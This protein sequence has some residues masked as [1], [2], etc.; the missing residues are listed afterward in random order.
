MFI[1]VIA[2]GL[3][4]GLTY[5]LVASGFNLAI[6]VCRILNFAHGEFYML[7]AFGVYYLFELLGLNYSLAII[8]SMAIVASLGIVIERLL[9][10]R[11]RGQ[12]LPTMITACAVMF[13]IA[14]AALVIFGEKSSGVS[15]IFSGTT[16]V[17]GASIATERWVIIGA[18]IMIIV[19]LHLFIRNTKTGRS[20][21][22][23]A[24]DTVGAALQG[25][26]IDNVSSL[27]MGLS[28]ALAAVAGGLMA[29]VFVVSPFLGSHALLNAFVVAVLG[30]MGSMPGAV[31]GGLL[32]GLLESFGFT[33][34]G[35]FAEVLVLFLVM[36]VILIKPGGLLGRPMVTEQ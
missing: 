35:C 25:I 22:A 15:S 13:F 21:R 11:L 4:I 30:G 14:G 27:S 17:F 26:N 9:F 24:Q 10:R 3:M 31:V 1:Q 36:V 33:Y 28:C 8:L 32:L 23:V 18:S 2:N 29:P 16:T 19:L 6:G 5:A 7:G 34:I 12:E 20:M